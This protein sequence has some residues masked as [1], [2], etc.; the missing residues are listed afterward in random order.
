MPLEV[1][2][3]DDINDGLD[4]GENILD[5]G[6]DEKVEAGLLRYTSDG[7]PDTGDGMPARPRRGSGPYSRGSPG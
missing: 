4:P 6:A 7:M 3:L 2:T 5:A 1:R